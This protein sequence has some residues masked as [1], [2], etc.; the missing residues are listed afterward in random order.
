VGCL[1]VECL[2]CGRGWS[3]P[4]GPSVYEQQALES[5]PCPYC[6]ACVLAV[7]EEES[8]REAALKGS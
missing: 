8:P 2:E 1:S 5:S 6:G 4:F 3:L 7:K